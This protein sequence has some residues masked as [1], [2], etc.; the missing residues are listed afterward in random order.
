MRLRQ[1][2]LLTM[3]R[4]LSRQYVIVAMNSVRIDTKLKILYSRP[5]DEIKT[6]TFVTPKNEIDFGGELGDNHPNACGFPTCFY[7][8]LYNNMDQQERDSI[9]KAKKCK[10]DRGKELYKRY[11]SDLGRSLF[12]QLSSLVEITKQDFLSYPVRFSC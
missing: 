1:L 11:Y 10:C 3:T 5:G 9:G 2:L 8:D 12:I 4:N 6:Y 7:S